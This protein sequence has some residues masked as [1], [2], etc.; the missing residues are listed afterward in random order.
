MTMITDVG[1]PHLPQDAETAPERINEWK[2]DDAARAAEVTAEAEAAS[3]TEMA[4]EEPMPYRLLVRAH[5]GLAVRPA[6]H[7]VYIM[8]SKRGAH[9]AE[10]EGVEYPK[11]GRSK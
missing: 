9:H 11:K 4:H 2:A 7:V 10:I 1:G 5:D 3:E 8:P 6:G